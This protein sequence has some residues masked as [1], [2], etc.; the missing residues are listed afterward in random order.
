MELRNKADRLDAISRV[1]N[2]IEQAMKYDAME[3]TDEIDENGETV[4]K[5]P[6]EDDWRY[7]N[8]KVW[9]EVLDAV[10]KLAE[11]K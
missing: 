8:Y 1:Y 3:W 11:K 7:V 2:S 9:Q 5:A 4:Y 10:V 6:K